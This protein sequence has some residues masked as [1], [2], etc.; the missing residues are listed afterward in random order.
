MQHSGA[1]LAVNDVITAAAGDEEGDDEDVQV[2]TDDQGGDQRPLVEVDSQH[3]TLVDTNNNQD[4]HEHDDNDKDDVDEDEDATTN[5][6]SVGAQWQLPAWS[7]MP[8]FGSALHGEEQV[9]VV[10]SHVHGM[11]GSKNT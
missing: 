11:L 5:E 10:G 6:G 2:G 9:S 1:S 4:S 7:K 3:L 8:I